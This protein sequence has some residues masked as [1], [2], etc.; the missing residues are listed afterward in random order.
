LPATLGSKFQL[1]DVKGATFRRVSAKV[2]VQ[3]EASSWQAVWKAKAPLDG[4]E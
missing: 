1:A 2:I 4:S 3:P